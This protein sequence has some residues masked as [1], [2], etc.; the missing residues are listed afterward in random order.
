[1]RLHVLSDLHLEQDPVVPPGVEADVIVLAGDVGNGTRGVDW[2]RNWADGRPVLYVAGNHEFYGHSLPDLIDDLREAAAGSSVYV[3][4]NDEV[5]LDGIRFLGCTLWSD[6]EFG[7]REQRAEA[8]AFCERV[9]NDYEQISFGPGGRALAA[10]DTLK[11]HQVSRRW[12]ETMLARPYD[13]KTVIITHH[14]PLIRRVP[15]LPELR[16]LAGAFA[17][18]VTDLMGGDRV[19]MWIYG[20]THRVADLTLRGTRVLSN[21]Y[22]YPHQPVEG[23]DPGFVVELGSEDTR[24]APV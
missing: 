9:V 8:M 15:P 5:I 24:S 20:H 6:F 22:G 2:A 3:L 13:G 14:A 18:D 4:E 10:R 17:S 19:A 21:P 23:F 1:M 7:G 12:L 16:A 11:C